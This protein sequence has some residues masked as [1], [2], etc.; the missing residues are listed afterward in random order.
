MKMIYLLI[1]SISENDFTIL[2]IYTTFKIKHP[3]V[4]K[5]E[6]AGNQNR[7]CGYDIRF[8]LSHN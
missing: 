2:K 7:V 6:C 3:K 4:N 8:I 5:I 1:K